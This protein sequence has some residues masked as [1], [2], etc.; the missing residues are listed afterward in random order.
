LVGIVATKGAH[1]A[2]SLA[3]RLEPTSSPVAVDVPAP[4]AR[5]VVANALRLRRFR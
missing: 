4:P 3:R 2:D 5:N 1:P